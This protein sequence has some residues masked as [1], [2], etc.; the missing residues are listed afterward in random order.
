MFRRIL[1]SIIFAALLLAGQCALALDLPVCKVNGVDYY[2][3]KV[4]PRESIYALSRKLGVSREDIL[5]YNPAVVD[6]LRPQ[7][8]LLFPVADFAPGA[9]HEVC[10]EET[11]PAEASPE[12]TAA[13]QPVKP[14]QP[15]PEPEEEAE[16]TIAP[17]PAPEPE[18]GTVAP[19]TP[20]DSVSVAVL[21]PFMLDSERL[22]K[23]AENYSE[24]YRGMLMAVDTV[25][26]MNPSLH[27]TLT[28]FDTAGSPQRVA[29]LM[30][31]NS[32][33]DYDFIIAPDDSLS[34]ERIAL[35]ADESDANVINLFA[36]KNDTWRRHRSMVQANIPQ[37]LMYDSA[38]A[39]IRE[40][41]AGYTP[42]ILTATDIVADKQPFINRLKQSF[43]ADGTAYLEL[44]A[45][46]ALADTLTAGR[47]YLFIPAS[48]SREMLTRVADPL[49]QLRSDAIAPDD[50]RLFGY[51]EW[52]I[53]R[54]ALAD[55]LHQLNSVIYSRFATDTDHRP[56]RR[57]MQDYERWYGRAMNNM[58]PVYG[59]LGYD[60]M[61]W[62]LSTCESGDITRPYHGL[63]STFAL[64]QHPSDNGGM[65]NGALYFIH[66]QPD[67]TKFV[68]SL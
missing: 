57:A 47:R 12:E 14:V 54:G 61:R 49:L 51:P 56:T 68:R 1:S 44:P 38:I 41:L 19:A 7:Q 34:L 50:V 45:D 43:E 21:L 8:M 13:V 30:N 25:A 18:P 48:G 42:V 23:T 53:L 58:A 60:T 64:T 37:T 65:V 36:V 63:Q 67:G 52:V 62:M 59:L 20:A 15:E 5:R 2:Y 9:R 40:H 46:Y 29:S 3:Y 4:Q 31:S 28:A 26:A 55:K 27:I 16:Q 17:A 6:G 33:A 66:F 35:P 24:F 39:G 11:S 32:L 22:T 10:P